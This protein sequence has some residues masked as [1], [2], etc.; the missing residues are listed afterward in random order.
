VK[1]ITI[2]ILLTIST[3][4]V[5]AQQLERIRDVRHRIDSIQYVIHEYRDSMRVELRDYRDSLRYARRH[6]Y[7]AVP[8]GIHIGWGDQMFESLIWREEGHHIGL[9]EGGELTSDENFRYTQHCFIEYMYSVNYWYSFGLLAD[10]SGVIWDHVKRNHKGEELERLANRSF[11]NIALVP[12]IRFSYLH[13]DYVS[14]YSALGFGVN[15]NTG[16]E[17]DYKGRRTVASPVLNITLLGVRVGHGRWYGSVEVGGM[18]AFNS[19]DELYM[20]GSRI[21]TAAIGVRF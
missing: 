7:D 14:L 13:H 2:L 20:L 11:H 9:P 21:F 10:Y 17:L 6:A 5:S 3:L 15:I 8:H 16:T 12:T 18:T 19:P 4:L 1:R